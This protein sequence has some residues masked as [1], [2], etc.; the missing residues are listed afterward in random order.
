MLSRGHRYAVIL[1]H[2]A[3]I[4]K[5]YAVILKHYAVILKAY[6]VILEPNSNPIRT[7]G[8]HHPASDQRAVSSKTAIRVT[9]VFSIA[10]APSM[11]GT[12]IG[13]KTAFRA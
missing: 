11:H 7:S 12:V 2:Y 1:K 13:I 6:A 10:Y 4:L 3:V 5:H 9:L 8:K